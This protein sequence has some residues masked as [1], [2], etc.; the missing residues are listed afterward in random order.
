MLPRAVD[1]G[2]EIG[3]PPR[4]CSDAVTPFS[5]PIGQLTE[6]VRRK[7]FSVVLFDEIEKA[8]QRSTTP[9]C[10]CWRTGG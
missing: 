8:H 2:R 5:A 10:R 3:W 9:S 6:K 1:R 4:R 7:P